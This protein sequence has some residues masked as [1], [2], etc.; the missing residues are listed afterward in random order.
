M[1]ALGEPAT[2]A[3]GAFFPSTYFYTHGTR[4]LA[5]LKQAR[6]Q[7]QKVLAAAWNARATALPYTSARE[8]LVMASIIE[9]ETGAAEERAQIAGVF[10]RRL[11][12]GMRLQTDPTVIYGLGADFDGNLRR[13]DLR[14]DTPFNTYTRA[15]LPP[16]PIA[17]PGAASIAAAL[18]PAPGEALYFVA[19]GDGTHVFSSSLAAHQRAVRLFQKR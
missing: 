7:M 15:G 1:S 4:D 17:M 14:R 13:D 18:A 10:V 6:V 5:L 11:A 3:E 2:P 19:K 9:K 8:A 16:T 12:L